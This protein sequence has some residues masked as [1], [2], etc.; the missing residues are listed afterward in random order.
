MLLA[1]LHSQQFRNP[2]PAI[3]LAGLE[4]KAVYRVQVLDSP[5]S[6]ELSGAYLMSEGLT[7]PLKGDYDSAAVLLER[8]Q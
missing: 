5:G 6:R 1:F 4:E 7:L 3:R 8:V 2:A